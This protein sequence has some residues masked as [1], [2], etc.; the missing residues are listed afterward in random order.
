MP[1]PALFKLPWIRSVAGVSDR[2]EDERYEAYHP[3]KLRMP[4]LP[5]VAGT[6]ISVS[7]GGAAIRFHGWVADVPEQWLT[8]LNRG[9][10]LRLEG[11]IDAPMSCQIVTTESGVLRVQFARDDALR[12]R[13][14]SVVTDFTGALRAVRRPGRTYPG[15]KPPGSMTDRSAIELRAQAAEYRELATTVRT[16]AAAYTLVRLATAFEAVA[17]RK[18]HR[19]DLG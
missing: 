12:R 13:L 3:V 5:P 8:Q 19:P 10:E 1:L 15:Q 16:G 11:L 18:E 9:A 6:L 4:G 2:R 7:L 14:R 17:K